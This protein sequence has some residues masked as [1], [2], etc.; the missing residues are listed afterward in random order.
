M[1]ISLDTILFTIGVMNLYS[2]YYTY[3]NIKAAGKKLD[4]N[5][6]FIYGLGAILSALAIGIAFTI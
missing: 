5:D 1:F 2:T 6:G 3:R 4:A